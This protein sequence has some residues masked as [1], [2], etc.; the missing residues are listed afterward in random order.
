MIG[1]D[2]LELNLVR[3]CCAA[4]SFC[5]HLSP[6]AEEYVLQPDEAERDLDALAKVGHWKL[7]CSQG[8][9]P[10][11]NPRINEFLELSARSGVADRVG[12]LSNGMLL[13]KMPDSFWETC[14][15]LN[16]QLRV[17]RYKILKGETLAIAWE[18]AKEFGVD[19]QP[20]EGVVDEFLSIVKDQPDGGVKIWSECMWRFCWTAHRGYLYRCPQSAFFP[21]PLWGWDETI[22]GI[23]IEGI[24]EAKLQAFCDREQ[25]LATC[26]KC[27]G[28]KGGRVKWEN[29]RNKEEWLQKSTEQS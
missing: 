3:K 5:N 4:C 26:A 18:K 6:I 11:L 27:A 2:N 15:R 19:F 7:V 23:P 28:D 29:L 22:D 13:H 25:P 12:I 20:T 17:T 16:V 10:T 21:K 1:L 24:T 9:E 14:A 8:G